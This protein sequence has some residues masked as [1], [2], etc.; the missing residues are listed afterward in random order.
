M[1][2][3]RLSSLILILSLIVSPIMPETIRL[4]DTA[5]AQY[6]GSS[7]GASSGGERKK[8]PKTRRSQVLSKAAFN[9]I[10]SAQEALAESNHDTAMNIL[11][12][13]MKSDRYNPYEKGVAQQTTQT[14]YRKR[15]T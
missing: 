11:L 1:S 2:K 4:V 14:F 8:K 9:Q 3:L 5:S 13:M 12:N 15:Q 6:G 7:G 10:T